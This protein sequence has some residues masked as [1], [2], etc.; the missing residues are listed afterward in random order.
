VLTKS[1]ETSLRVT[2]LME[3]GKKFLNLK[4]GMNMQTVLASGIP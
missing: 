3:K 1:D 2:V 4:E